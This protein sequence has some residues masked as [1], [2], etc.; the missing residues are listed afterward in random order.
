MRREKRPRLD[1]VVEKFGHAPG[2]GKSVEGRRAAADLIEDHETAIARVVHDV[3]GLVHLHHESR[4]TAGEIV[5]RADP[6]ENAI[7]QSNLGA[8]CRDKTSDLRHQDNQRD[9]PDVGRLPGHVRPGDDGQSHPFAVEIGVVRHKLF[10]GQILIE[11]RMASVA[12][13]QAQRIVQRRPGITVKPRRL[14]ERAD[15]VERPNRR[16]R[17]LDRLQFAQ[18]LL[19]QG[20]EKLVLELSRL[21]VRAQNLRFHFLQLRRDETLAADGRLLANITFR[22]IPQ[23]RF[24]HLDEISEDGIEPDLERLDPGLRDLAF[25]Q[26]RDPVFPFARALPQFVQIGIEAVSKNSAFLQD[27]RRIVDQRR[28]QFVRQRWHFLK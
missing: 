14:R 7:H 12:D 27:H 17:L 13:H 11:H 2:D 15:H 23:I 9:L 5:V 18:R 28:R 19:A 4:L 1:L 8:R 26:L 3:R 20:L 21:F 24:R 16:R 22:D 25:L 6:G 10:F